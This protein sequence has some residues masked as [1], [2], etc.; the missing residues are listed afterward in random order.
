MII[1]PVL[2]NLIQALIQD[3]CLKFK[4]MGI[5]KTISE[6]ENDHHEVEMRSESPG[7]YCWD[8]TTNTATTSSNYHN[9]VKWGTPL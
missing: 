2:M 4:E 6:N 1:C 3:S 5:K 9:A 8:P 7:G